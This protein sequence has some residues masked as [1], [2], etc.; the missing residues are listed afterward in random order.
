MRSSAEPEIQAALLVCLELGGIAL[1][2]HLSRYLG[3]DPLSG[4]GVATVG[5]A[6]TELL[7]HGLFTD[8]RMVELHDGI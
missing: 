4:S 1:R 3:V 6:I 7:T 8:N 2:A 5:R